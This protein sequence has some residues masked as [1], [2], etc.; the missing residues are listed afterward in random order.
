MCVLEDVAHGHGNSGNPLHWNNINTLKDLK[1][2]PNMKKN[3]DNFTIKLVSMCV[4][5]GE[6]PYIETIST[7]L[8]F[9][10]WNKHVNF[11][12]DNLIKVA[13]SYMVVVLLW[14]F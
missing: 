4:G 12:M 13:H 7:F 8:K 5:I 14:Q 1:R 10:Q 11:V 6:N 3:K 9:K 2:D